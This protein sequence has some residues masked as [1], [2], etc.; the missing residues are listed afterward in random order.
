MKKSLVAILAIGLLQCAAYFCAFRTD[1]PGSGGF[2]PGS[3]DKGCYLQSAANLLEGH[4][5]TFTEGDE[6]S[7]GTTSV[8]YPVLLA[9]PMA[10]GFTGD[11]VNG[12]LFFLAA[13]IYLATLACWGVVITRLFASGFA[14]AVAVAGIGLSG[15]MAYTAFMQTD[16]LPWL[17]LCALIAMSP[18]GK[19]LILL[20]LAPWFRPE[21]A[22]LVIA[23]YLYRLLNFRP[24]TSN[25]GLL[26]L[27]PLLSLVALFAFNFAITGRFFATSLSAKGYLNL[28][29]PV[30]AIKCIASDVMHILL[31]YLF[32][33]PLEAQRFFSMPTPVLSLLFIVGAVAALRRFRLDSPI[34]IFYL[35]GAAAVYAVASST[36]SGLDYDRYLA[37]L[38]PFHALLAAFGTEVIHR[39]SQDSRRLPLVLCR[40]ALVFTSAGMLFP[41]VSMALMAEEQVHTL[42]E[43]L[44]ECREASRGLPE[45]SRT[46]TVNFF[47]VYELPRRRTV[48]DIGGLYSPAYAPGFTY[49]NA[50]ERMKYRPDLRVDHWL[51]WP[52]N[53]GLAVNAPEMKDRIFGPPLAAADTNGYIRVADWSAFDRALAAPPDV[54]G[55]LSDRL[56]VCFLEDEKRSCYRPVDP[57]ECNYVSFLWCADDGRGEAVFDCGRYVTAGEEFKLCAVPGADA[58][59]VLRT[60]GYV[61]SGAGPNHIVR[62][63]YPS[64][65]R[66]SVELDGSPLGDFEIPVRRGVF[67]DFSIPIPAEKIKRPVLRFSIRGDFAS[68]GYRLY[69]LKKSVSS[70]SL[71]SAVLP[72]RSSTSATSRVPFL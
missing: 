59:L 69:D 22:M 64:P 23:F 33:I 41:A 53:D 60:T 5:F 4:P 48:F 35:A 39:L 47:A 12:P 42:G 68:F 27:F 65:R 14:R 2:E 31:P 58:A 10:L 40:A 13:F 3:F 66:I 57:R 37:W 26:S 52:M 45:G 11:A 49:A 29:A 24:S 38:V 36:Y 30:V 25:S 19:F 15:L 70:A 17:L 34:W 62:R 46:G 8:L 71:R 20:A 72:R 55:G 9:V 56:D 50:L 18:D 7:T 51:V 63:E 61:E 21:G 32:S 67:T 28:A 16:Q 6:P 44:A 43:K 1:R 54:S